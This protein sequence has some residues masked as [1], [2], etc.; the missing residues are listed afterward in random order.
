MDQAKKLIL[1]VDEAPKKISEWIILA[2]QHVLAMFVACITVPL[3]VF[4]G[5]MEVGAEFANA[6]AK[7]PFININGI[8][9][10]Q[11]MIAP[12]LVAAGIGTLFYIVFPL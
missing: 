9:L 2:I 12:T 3:L 1:D 7:V 5:P 10:A 11:T 4:S 8:S 6:G